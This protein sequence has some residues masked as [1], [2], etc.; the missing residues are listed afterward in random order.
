MSEFTETQ[1]GSQHESYG[2]QRC[3]LVAEIAAGMIAGPEY[4]D[5]S[6]ET[7]TSD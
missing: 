1:W 5:C 2:F 3:R 6:I 4:E 7:K